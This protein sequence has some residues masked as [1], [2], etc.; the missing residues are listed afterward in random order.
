MRQNTVGSYNFQSNAFLII[1]F[2]PQKPTETLNEK[3]KV[4]SSSVFLDKHSP[5]PVTSGK[6]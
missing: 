4:S 5:P 2:P 1:Q 3:V 6:R